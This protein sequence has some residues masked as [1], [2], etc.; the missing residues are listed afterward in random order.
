[1]KCF[2]GESSQVSRERCRSRA[3]ERWRTR[4]HPSWGH[5]YTVA[6]TIGPLEIVACASLVW[7]VEALA[8]LGCL[9]ATDLKSPS[10]NGTDNQL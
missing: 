3:D 1:M 9:P 8:S 2:L 4:T 5:E 7:A 10:E 6:L